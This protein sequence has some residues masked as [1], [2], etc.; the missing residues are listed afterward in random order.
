M[1]FSHRPT[2]S[3]KAKK[4]AFESHINLLGKLSVVPLGHSACV[5]QKSACFYEETNKSVV[6]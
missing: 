1:K 2:Y 4:T 3:T 6:Y 5:K